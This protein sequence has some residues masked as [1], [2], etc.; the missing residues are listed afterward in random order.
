[1]SIEP[2]RRQS[3]VSL[4]NVLGLTLL[5]YIATMYFAHV[6]GP[7]VLG[8]YYLFL[9]YY[10]V[11]SLIGDG[12][13]GGAAA[14]RISEGREPDAF[15]TAFIVLRII[16]LTVSVTAV[17]AAASFFVDFTSSGLL[18]WLILALIAG[19]LY[20]FTYT[21][22]YGSGKVGLAQGSDFMNTSIKIVLQILATFL[23]YGAAGLVGGFI[24]GLTAGFIINFSYLPLKLSKFNRNHLKSLF[25]FSFWIFLT[26]SSF[27][28]FSTA[29]TILIGYYLSN[30]EVGIYRVAYQLTG[31]ASFIAVALNTVLFPRISRWNT[32]GSFEQ[33]TGGLS[34]AF[35][36][37]MFLA[38]PVVAGGFIL[39]DK[40][41]YYLYGS[42]FVTGTPA[43]V[44]LLVMQIS[45]IFVML[46]ITCL[47]AID[48][49]KRSFLATSISALVNIG[50][51]IAL[52][53]VIGILG[54]AI[55]TFFSI[56]LNALLANYYLSKGI[57]VGLERG[58][59]LHILIAAAV[60]SLVV[61]GYRFGIG[62]SSF[63]N[64]LIGVIIG[65]VVYFLFL[66][67]I[68]RR[69]QSEISDLMK[70]VGIL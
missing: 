5:G 46:Q 8:S 38:I 68:D 61:L 27:T 18:P 60:M 10:S 31:A 63:A 36:F 6:L 13:F 21:A 58:P 15:F 47:N 1:M 62:I 69:L 37:S 65:G 9:A 11:F 50:L 34:K 67:W 53:P 39:G 2:I 29:D 70:T 33:I 41:L 56:T 54:A 22:I 20:S 19:T 7:A 25:V 52:I 43:L 64:L 24:A 51:N 28:I 4:F 26:S 57:K 48:Q 12:G 3:L 55:A 30:T 40:L 44:V 17:I 66:F 16:F 42:D 14:K 23:G 32:D 49:P 45:S 35:S 59:I